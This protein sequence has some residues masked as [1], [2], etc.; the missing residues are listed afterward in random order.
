MSPNVVTANLVEGSKAPW[1]RTV[2]KIRRQHAITH[3]RPS[4]S[5]SFSL[6]PLPPLLPS[7][8]PDKW[9]DAFRPTQCR[10]GPKK[11]IGRSCSI[12]QAYLNLQSTTFEREAY[13]TLPVY[14]CAFLVWKRAHSRRSDPVE[15]PHFFPSSS[16]QGSTSSGSHPSID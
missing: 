12:G 15:V 4:S 1:Y 11:K 10:D 2:M 7:H 13:C 5:S 14:V 3:R 9:V 6:S 8:F 16:V